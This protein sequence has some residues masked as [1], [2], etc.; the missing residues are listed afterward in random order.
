MP[1][2]LQVFEVAFEK[3]TSNEMGRGRGVEETIKTLCQILPSGGK[4]P[5]CNL[6]VNSPP[7]SNS[8]VQIPLLF[9]FL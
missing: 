4:F 2:F 5:K 9:K 7:K 6:V 3:K 8:A 1:V